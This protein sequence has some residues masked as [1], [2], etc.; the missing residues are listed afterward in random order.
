MKTDLIDL[1]ID[2]AFKL[3]FCREGQEPV[4]VAFLNAVLKPAEG[5]KIRSLTYT[6]TELTKANAED[7]KATLDIR[8]ELQD[9][10]HVNIEI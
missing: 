4:L 2:F 7:K 9:G 5:K 6:N 3:I 1:K 8:A 10:R